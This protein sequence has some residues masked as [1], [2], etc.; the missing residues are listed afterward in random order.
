MS[1]K[2]LANLVDLMDQKIDP[3]VLIKL[4][5]GAVQEQDKSITMLNNLFEFKWCWQIV[6]VVLIN[7]IGFVGQGRLSIPGI[8]FRDGVGTGSTPDE[9][10]NSAFK[11]AINNLGFLYKAQQKPEYQEG[12]IP[13][14]EEISTK[15]QKLSKVQ[16]VKLKKLTEKLN[17]K[18]GYELNFYVTQYAPNLT[19]INELDGATIDGFLEYLE[20]QTEES[21]V[22]DLFD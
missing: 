21:K 15:K 14:Q 8:G 16:K 3:K 4:K 6:S 1:D 10:A 2:G 17:I 18:D 22:D 5:N 11:N 19:N 13:A 7:E 9:A 20:K 12:E